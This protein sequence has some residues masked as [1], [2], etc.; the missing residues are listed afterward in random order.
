MTAAEAIDYLA[1]PE[2]GKAGI[3]N[4]V[5][6]ALRTEIL[7]AVQAAKVAKAKEDEGAAAEQSGASTGM[8]GPEDDSEEAMR[9][10]REYCAQAMAAAEKIDQGGDGAGEAAM[11]PLSTAA[12]TPESSDPPL[13]KP[14][15]DPPAEAKAPAAGSGATS[16]AA[17]PPSGFDWGETF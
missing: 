4:T 6:E 2:P 16:D 7:N 11:P 14:R 17:P 13:F 15:A 9:K 12:A 8:S 1:G 5:V 10:W 3:S